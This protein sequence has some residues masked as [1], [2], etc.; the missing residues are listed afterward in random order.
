MPGFS[1]IFEVRKKFGEGILE[2]IT[3]TFY[4]G[5]NRS[6]TDL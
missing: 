3:Q 2:N 4:R 5:K 6:H 1:K